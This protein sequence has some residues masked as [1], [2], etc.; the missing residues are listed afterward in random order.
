[1]DWNP[2]IEVNVSPIDHYWNSIQKN[3]REYFEILHIR[4][5]WG[6]LANRAKSMK[7]LLFAFGRNEFCCIWSKSI[8]C[9][10][11]FRFWEICRMT[12]SSDVIIII[13]VLFAMITTA[14]VRRKTI[15]SFSFYLIERKNKKKAFFPGLVIARR[16]VVSYFDES[17]VEY[18]VM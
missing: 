6:K 8:I 13:F 3:K 7:K 16:S 1:M 9:V 2:M 18:S 14:N 10:V 15:V 5:G 12:S 17:Q 11:E 4:T